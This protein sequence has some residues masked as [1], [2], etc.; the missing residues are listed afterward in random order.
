MI[1]LI[2]FNTPIQGNDGTQ[3]GAQPAPNTDM[4][5]QIN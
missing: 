4:L 5:N 3:R 1:A 2:K